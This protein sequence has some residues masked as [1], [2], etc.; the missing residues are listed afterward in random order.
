LQEILK[1]YIIDL[2]EAEKKSIQPRW[3]DAGG[4]LM[5][6]SRNIPLQDNKDDCGFFMLTFAEI[7]VLHPCTP[8]NAYLYGGFPP[9]APGCRRVSRYSTPACGDI[10]GRAFNVYV[11]VGMIIS[12]LV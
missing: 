3:T 2:H 9:S 10:V 7:E 11:G 5:E 12:V 1:Q 4:C 6:C 8:A